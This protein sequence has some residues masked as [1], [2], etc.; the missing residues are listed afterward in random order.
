MGGVWLVLVS[1][2]HVTSPEE[3]G[4]LASDWR[5]TKEGSYICGIKSVGLQ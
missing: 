5:V 2:L 3:E 1:H 4:A